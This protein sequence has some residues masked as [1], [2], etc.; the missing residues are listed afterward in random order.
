MV[1]FKGKVLKV[2]KKQLRKSFSVKV[3]LKE[4]VTGQASGQYNHSFNCRITSV[5]GRKVHANFS[6]D[7]ISD[8]KSYVVMYF[9]EML[10]VFLESNGYYISEVVNKNGECVLT[11]DRSALED[12]KVEEPATDKDLDRLFKAVKKLKRGS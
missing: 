2:V 9:C 4:E 5:L 12:V 11:V 1:Y 7:E 6:F 10:K 8:E 3:I